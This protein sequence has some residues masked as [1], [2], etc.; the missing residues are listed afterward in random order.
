MGYLEVLNRR[1]IRASIR[2]GNMIWLDPHYLVTPD[3]AEAV[4]SHKDEILVDIRACAADTS[5]ELPEIVPDYQFL[6]VATDR[7]YW[8]ADDPRFGYQTPWSQARP[9]GDA[10][11]ARVFS[12][13]CHFLARRAESH[14]NA[15]TGEA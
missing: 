5:S 6:M 15:R 11:I 7:D 13:S 3:I 2:Q 14:G 9:P 12:R 8:E 1:G 10:S 4:R